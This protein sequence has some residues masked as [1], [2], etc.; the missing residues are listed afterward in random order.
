VIYLSLISVISYLNRDRA[1]G[2]HNMSARGLW[3]GPA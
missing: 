2:K 3:R 1:K